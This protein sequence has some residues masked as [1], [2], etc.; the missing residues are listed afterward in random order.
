MLKTV[1]RTDFNTLTVE[2]VE[3]ICILYLNVSGRVF[4]INQSKEKFIEDP[5]S[6]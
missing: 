6:E 5:I 2:Y 3:R 1:L 4:Q